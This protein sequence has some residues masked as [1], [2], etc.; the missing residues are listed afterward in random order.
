MSYGD[1][2][3]IHDAGRVGELD[4]WRYF[5]KAKIPDFPGTLLVLYYRT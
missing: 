1:G 5:H 2:L 4:G 3:M